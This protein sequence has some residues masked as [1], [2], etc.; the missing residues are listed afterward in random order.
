MLHISPILSPKSLSKSPLCT[1]DFSLSLK[2][3]SLIASI[4]F[5]V[6]CSK[7]ST[8]FSLWFLIAVSCFSKA[9]PIGE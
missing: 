5:A 4:F 3:L 8:C 2:L 7:A 9:L 1:E 6:E